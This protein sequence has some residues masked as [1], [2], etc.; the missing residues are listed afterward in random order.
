MLTPEGTCVVAMARSKRADANNEHVF[1]LIESVEQDA[2]DKPAFYRFRR[3]ELFVDESVQHTT[4]DT[5]LNR[6]IL[7]GKS[8]VTL[9]E[10][11]IT[12]MQML[13]PDCEYRG[14]IID[15]EQ[16]NKLLSAIESDIWQPP[17]VLTSIA[18]VA[19]CRYTA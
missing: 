12:D 4:L 19:N 1:L 15:T 7:A 2:P 11:P 16:K 17:D 18:S 13:M 8:K 9:N 14:F 6:Y 3:A 10:K 5:R